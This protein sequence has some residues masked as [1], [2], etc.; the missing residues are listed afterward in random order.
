MLGRISK[1]IAALPFIRLPI[2]CLQESV[3]YGEDLNELITQGIVGISTKI[4]VGINLELDEPLAQPT[5]IE[6]CTGIR[7]VRLLRRIFFVINQRIMCM[8]I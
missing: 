6:R 8:P 7:M 4:S 3:L 1:H 2:F 5:N